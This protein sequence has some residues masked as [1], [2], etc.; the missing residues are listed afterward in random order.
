MPDWLT[1]S[2]AAS[3]PRRSV[4]ATE[5]N[6]STERKSTPPAIVAFRSSVGKGVIVRIPDSPAVS[7]AQL[8]VLPPPS[9][10]TMPMPVT[11]TI[12][13]PS[14]SRG[15]VM[16]S[17]PV[18][19]AKS[20]AR[21]IHPDK[22]LS[23]R[24]DQGHAFTPPMPGRDHH[25]LGRRLRHFNLHAGGIPGRKQGTARHRHRGKG[26]SKGELGFHGM[27]EPRTRRAYR[28]I[29]MFGKKSAFFRGRRLGP[30]RAGN[31]GAA[32]LDR[33]ELRPQLFQ[34][35]GD[36][37][38]LLAA[39]MVGDR[40]REFCEGFCAARL[41]MRLGLQHQEGAG[42]A[43]REAGMLLAVPHG[44]E[45]VPY[46]EI[47][48]LVEDHQVFTFSIVRAADQ[49]DVALAGGNAR[50]CNA[51]RVDARDLFAHESA[52]GAADAMDDCDIAGEKV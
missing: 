48:E 6:G 31:D 4:S 47:A 27:A 41:R 13:R 3:S 15:A 30:A 37:A 12:G 16:F 10:V 36:V 25:N 45:F 11:T 22:I 38:G 19:S 28:E 35:R 7:F 42:R 5:V 34:R 24:L 43:E 29:G 18:P 32:A 46:E 17:P 49:H 39:A 8:S 2:S 23:D 9:E 21:K 14:L 26:Q 44:D 52:R 33:A 40:A 20:F 1:A 51:R 50:E